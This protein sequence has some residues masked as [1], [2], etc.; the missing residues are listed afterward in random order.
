MPLRAR[1]PA[2]AAV[3][4]LSTATRKS[5]PVRGW[6]VRDLLKIYCFGLSATLVSIEFGAALA[7]M[8]HVG[9]AL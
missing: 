4:I 5:A 6:M 7:A 2:Q 3:S 9:G 8:Y 1:A